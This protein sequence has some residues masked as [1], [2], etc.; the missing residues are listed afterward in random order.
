MASFACTSKISDVV[1]PKCNERKYSTTTCLY[2]S[3]KYSPR[4]P[5]V[6]NVVLEWVFRLFEYCN[7]CATC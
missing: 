6:G 1:E 4:R 2:A 7:M 3:E 5:A